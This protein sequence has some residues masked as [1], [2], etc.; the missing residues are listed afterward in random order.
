MDELPE[1]MGRQVN[2]GALSSRNDRETCQVEIMTCLSEPPPIIQKNAEL[3]GPVIIGGVGGSGTR[4]VAEIVRHL[5][6][7]IGEDLNQAS[8]NLWFLLLF[9]R[10]RWFQRARHDQNKI[11][12]GLSLLSTAMHHRAVPQWS[13]LRFLMGAVFEIAI[14]GHNHQ[15]DGRGLWPFVRAWNM[16]AR[17]PNKALSQSRWGWKEPNSHIYL[18][19]L[20]GY[21]SNIKY[22]HTI[23]HGLDMAFSEN[24]QQLFNWGPIIGL[25]LPQSKAD[26]PVASLKY[27]IKSNRRVTEIGRKLGDQK[28]LEVNFDRMCLSPESEI[29]KIVSF[30]NIVPDAETRAVLCRIPQKPESLG[31][32]RSRDISRFD[33]ADLEELENL[34]FST[35]ADGL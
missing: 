3:S 19:Y 16:I 28:F 27:W 8:D 13:E 4:V 32:Y 18:E 1:D 25:E 12:T 11:F 15:G 9:K 17:P 22:I 33:Q 31:R 29:Q 24:Q 7:Y 20:A 26:E 10:P 5:G 35:A 21:F 2:T 30:L 34:G 14:F 6:F 23:R